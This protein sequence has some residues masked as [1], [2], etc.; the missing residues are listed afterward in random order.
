MKATLIVILSALAL[1]PAAAAAQRPPSTGEAMSVHP[2]ARTA[3]DRIKSPYCP[4][5]ML[6]VCT[7]EGGAMLRDSIQ[8]MAGRGLSADSI[9]E[10]II[11]QYGE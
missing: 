8:R 3:I 1:L 5:M 6:E 4:G 11:G 9:V 2:E 7:S 10:V